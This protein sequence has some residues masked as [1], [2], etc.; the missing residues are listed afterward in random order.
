MVF[1]QIKLRFI[2]S[3]LIQTT[4][5]MIGGDST[6]LT[7]DYQKGHNYCVVTNPNL[8]DVGQ[9]VGICDDD[10]AFSSGNLLRYGWTDSIIVC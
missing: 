7:A 10:N 9:W 6:L 1:L 2:Q 3:V 8:F 4:I 5:K